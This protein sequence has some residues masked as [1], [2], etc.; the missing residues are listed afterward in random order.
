[1]VTHQNINFKMQK[2]SNIFFLNLQVKS[3]T[4]APGKDANGVSHEATNSLDIIENIQAR[5]PSSA[6][7]VNAAS[8]VVIILHCTWNVTFK[9]SRN[10][11]LSSSSSEVHSTKVVQN[12]V[13][14]FIEI[15][16]LMMSLSTQTPFLIISNEVRKP[17]GSGCRHIG[18]KW[19]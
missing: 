10:S 13:R 12:F 15:N 18:L 6:V 19:T 16:F 8:H 9:C 14:F 4:S 11:S 17:D 7:T 2:N 3:P 5:S 1:M